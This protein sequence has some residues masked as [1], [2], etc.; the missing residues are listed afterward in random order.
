MNFMTEYKERRAEAQVLAIF[1]DQV[2]RGGELMRKCR[3]LGTW[4]E[5]QQSVTES[6]EN[7]F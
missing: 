3:K 4:E 2:L 7:E 5:S 6:K 1:C